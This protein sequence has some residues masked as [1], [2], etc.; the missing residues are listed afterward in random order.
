MVSLVLGVKSPRNWLYIKDR[1]TAQVKNRPRAAAVSGQ[2]RDCR[3]FRVAIG[4]TVRLKFGSTPYNAS[5]VNSTTITVDTN[6][7]RMDRPTA[8]PTPTGPPLAL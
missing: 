1:S 6:E 3:C 2:V 4:Y 5:E 7:K 8:S